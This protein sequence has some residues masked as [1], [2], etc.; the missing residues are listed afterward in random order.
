MALSRAVMHRVAYKPQKYIPHSSGGKRSTQS[1][2]K[3]QHLVGGSSWLI[4]AVSCCALM[5]WEKWQLSGVPFMRQGLM[6]V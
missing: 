4:D 2:Q 3:I 6:R 1:L 5:Q